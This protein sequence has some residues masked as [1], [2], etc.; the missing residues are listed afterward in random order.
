MLEI[1]LEKKQAYFYYYMCVYLLYSLCNL[2]QL[3]LVFICY[4]VS[5]ESEKYVN[6]YWKRT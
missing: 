1:E 3:E 5:F 4:M 2:V 6:E